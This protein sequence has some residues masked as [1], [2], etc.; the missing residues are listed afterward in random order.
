M[1]EVLLGYILGWATVMLIVVGSNQPVTKYT[2]DRAELAC[3][4]N[5]GLLEINGREFKCANGA[6]FKLEDK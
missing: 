4:D 3:V 5:K 2:I 6:V 1:P